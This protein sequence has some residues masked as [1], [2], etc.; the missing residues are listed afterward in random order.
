LS[1]PANP[2]APVI[3]FRELREQ[4]LWRELLAATS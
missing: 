1:E 4:P 3:P 2:P